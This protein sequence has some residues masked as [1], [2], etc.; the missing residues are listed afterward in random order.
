MKE[1]KRKV[2]KKK[3]EQGRT[4][5]RYVGDDFWVVKEDK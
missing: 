1:E 3:D 5:Y 2:E 4:L